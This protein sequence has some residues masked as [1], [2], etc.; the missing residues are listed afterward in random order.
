MPGHGVEVLGGML[1]APGNF[2]FHNI[3]IHNYYTYL[4]GVF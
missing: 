2:R 1:I 4:S 3:I